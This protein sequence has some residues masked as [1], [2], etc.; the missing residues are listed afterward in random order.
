MSDQIFRFADGKV[1]IR[2]ENGDRYFGDYEDGKITGK[3]SMYYADGRIYEGQFLEGHYHGYGRARYLNGAVFEG[4][5][6]YN[7]F[8]GSGTLR[9][10]RGSETATMEGTWVRHRREGKGK[11]TY[12]GED[13]SVKLI[14]EGEYHDDRL[15]GHVK[16]TWSDGRVEETEYVMGEP[17]GK[18]EERPD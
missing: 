15:N 17:V 12:I 14:V 6:C 8:N 2:Y 9:L 18:P 10:I 13:G 11:N 1:E 7:E 4:T 16:K 3:G 5:F